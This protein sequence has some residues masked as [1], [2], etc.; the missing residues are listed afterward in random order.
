MMKSVLLAATAALALSTTALRA[1]PIQLQYDVELRLLRGGV[2]VGAPNLTVNAG[3]RATVMSDDGTNGLSLQLIATP[4]N[5]KST[6]LAFDVEAWSPADGRWKRSA[7]LV[8]DD[9]Q[10][11]VV[12]LA[13]NGPKTAARMEIT[14]HRR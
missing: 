5:A 12:E 11:A 10:T 9:G 13:P 4:T 2:L 14:L 3:E 6:S 8:V 1:G 7:A